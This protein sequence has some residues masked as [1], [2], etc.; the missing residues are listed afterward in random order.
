MPTS[1]ENEGKPTANNIWV[2]L[3]RENNRTYCYDVGSNSLLEIDD[4]LADVLE[5]YDY[6]NQ[7][8]VLES[9]A[10][11]YPEKRLQEALR[12][13]HDFNGESGGFIPVK[14]IR[15]SFPFTK[16][17]YRLLLH[18]LVNHVV[19]NITEDCNFRCLYCQYGETYQYAR[20][21]APRS[22]PLELI[23]ASID[24]MVSRADHIIRKTDRNL[25]VGFYGGEP[26]LEKDKIFQALE[27]IKKNY[28]DIF[29]RFSFNM[30][31]NGSLLDRDTI[32]RLVEYDF[33][34]VISLDGSQETHDR[35]RVFKD[36]DVTFDVIKKKIDLIKWMAPEYF[37]NKVKFNVV[38]A[39][40][41]KIKEVV[42]FFRKHFPGTGCTFS[43]V[44]PH[45]TDFFDNFNM[46]REYRQYDREFKEIEKEY[47]D[48]KAAGSGNHYLDSLFDVK[49]LEIHR[50]LQFPMPDTVFPNGICLP[51]LKRIFVDV[52]GGIHMC[53]KINPG[54]GIGTI[55]DGF[56]F[57]AIFR[58]IDRY[59]ET[60]N[61]CEG[62]WA[63]RFCSECFLSSI[64]GDAFSKERKEI[65]CRLRE[66]KLLADFRTYTR[67]MQKA[68]TSLDKV[69]VTSLPDML[70]VAV[71]FLEKNH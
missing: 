43:P 8:E 64:K 16:D 30:T 13:I 22:M 4:T 3:F 57:D 38:T 70:T 17:Q 26:L 69:T 47:I 63:V 68:P 34:L 45:D 2:K 21:H 6:S 39:P 36:H 18:N 7:S 23:T 42:G 15:L 27:Y 1:G 61:H 58:H 32:Q 41:F 24:F 59:I 66:E 44:S 14:P 54:F 51:G 33:S 10:G 28:R 71:D 46:K 60:T 9:L 29:P 31:V 67:L 12:T 25:S 35:Y 55:R 49:L 37:K 20:P 48:K 11:K 40:E 65:N 52:D 19:L 5:I 50:R 62:C 53:E 56:D